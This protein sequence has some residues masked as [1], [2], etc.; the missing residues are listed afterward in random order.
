ML[1]HPEFIRQGA[2]DYLQRARRTASLRRS[3]KSPMPSSIS[4][5]QAAIVGL[6]AFQLPEH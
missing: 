5:L 3:A 2:D 4:P 1:F 6:K